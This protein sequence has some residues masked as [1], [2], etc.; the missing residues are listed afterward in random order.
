MG[1]QIPHAY[2]SLAKPQILPMA[3]TRPDPRRTVSPISETREASQRFFVG[4]RKMPDLAPQFPA[5]LTYAQT[6]PR[7]GQVLP[8]IGSTCPPICRRQQE[9]QR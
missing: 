8:S 1:T 6:K 2:L 7:T 4:C 9:T 5:A 3:Y